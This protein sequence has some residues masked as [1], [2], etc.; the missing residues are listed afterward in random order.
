MSL[1]DRDQIHGMQ[2]HPQVTRMPRQTPADIRDITRLFHLPNIL[3]NQSEIGL[4]MPDASCISL[5]KAL[6]PCK[7]RVTLPSG[8]VLFGMKVQHC[9]PIMEQTPP[10]SANMSRAILFWIV[11]FDVG[12]SWSER[13]SIVSQVRLVRRRT[14]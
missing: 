1:V 7:A 12:R 4:S 5:D 6:K 9:S 10:F 2:K 14:L 11:I 8:A 3:L 13:P